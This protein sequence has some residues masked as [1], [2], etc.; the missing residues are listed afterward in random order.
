MI[1]SRELIGTHDI[2]FVTLDTLRFDVAD[3]E[4]KAGRTPNLQAVLPGQQWEPR[5]SPASFTYA[6]HHAFFAGFLPTPIAPGRHPRLFAMRFEGSETTSKQT[7]V[8]D[9]SNIVE[10]LAALGYHTICIG[11]VG[12][13][14]KQNPLGLVLPSLFNE[15]H[16]THD[17]GV[18]SPHSTE[19]QIDIA[20]QRVAMLDSSRRVFLFVNI[21]ALHQPNRFYV[22]GAQQDTI[23]THA[24]ALRYV[25]QHLPRLFRVLQ[26]RAPVLTILCSDHGTAYGDDGYHGHRLAHPCTWTVPYA[27]TIL[28]KIDA[29]E[30]T[31]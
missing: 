18:T 16:W 28:P 2:L 4:L 22:P 27:E 1:H 19:R 9:A 6:A 21:S 17:T 12:F 20:E 14:N 10:G 15:S 29:N 13:F 11:G 23:E 24:A 3:R 8:L 30:A 7:L 5:H 31:R 25:D 26:R